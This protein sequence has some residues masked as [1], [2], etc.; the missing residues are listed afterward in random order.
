MTNFFSPGLN[1]TMKNLLFTILGGA[2]I[3]AAGCSTF[4]KSDTNTLQGTWKGHDKAHPTEGVCT[5]KFSK[6]TVDFQ[7]VD[8]DDWC[9]GIFTLREDADPKQ[10]VA[11]ILESPDPR[12][13]G[14]SIHAIYKIEGETLT[15]A[16]N[17]PGD[18]GVPSNFDAP[19]LRTLVL[20]KP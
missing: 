4:H 3:V 19:N 1:R 7:G 16:G 9:K 15:L 11:T 5:V 6:S 13:N 2:L 14:Q 12:A 10:I 17:P 18:P 8:K 20:K